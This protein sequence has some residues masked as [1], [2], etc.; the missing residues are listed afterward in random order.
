MKDK[1]ISVRVDKEL[2]KQLSKKL[3]VD[4][5]KTLR[6]CMNCTYF[7]IHRLFGG[8]LTYI[9]RRSKINEERDLYDKF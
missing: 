2:L 3:G 4:E 6:A 9:F 1:L 5:S 8:E 7:V